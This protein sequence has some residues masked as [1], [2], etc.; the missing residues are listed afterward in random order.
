MSLACEGKQST[1]HSAVSRTSTRGVADTGDS[2]SRVHLA[3]TRPQNHPG[4]SAGF[5]DAG[6]R[7]NGILARR[8]NLRNAH[9]KSSNEAYLGHVMLFGGS[10]TSSEVDGQEP[11]AAQHISA[12]LAEFVLAAVVI[13]GSAA[14]ILGYW[15]AGNLVVQGT[16]AFRALKDRLAANRVPKPAADHPGPRQT[17]G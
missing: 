6:L 14:A 9:T 16:D 1:G 4:S 10:M 17:S 8:S 5:G 3:I 7:L 12:R 13:A 11:V 15:A 2:R